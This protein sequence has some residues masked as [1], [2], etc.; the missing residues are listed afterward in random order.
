MAQF[1]RIYRL[2]W[3]TVPSVLREDLT[4]P[5]QVMVVN[6]YD[7]E[8]LIEDFQTPEVI[9]LQ[10]DADPLVI[11]IINNDE[12]KFS[13]IRA[14]Q[15]E[16]SFK[17]KTNLNQYSSTFAD[18]S[19]HRWK[20][21]ITADGEFVFIGFVVLADVEQPHLP[22]PNTVTLTASDHLGIL[23]DIPWTTDAGINPQGKYRI[24]DIIALCLK[25]TGLR[26]GITAVNNLRHGTGSI[27]QGATFLTSENSFI[28][29]IVTTFFYTGQQVQ[30]TGSGAN[31][32][33]FIVSS[34]ETTALTTKVF[35][36]TFTDDSVS[37]VTF[38]DLSSDQHFYDEIFLDA[39]TFETEI[40]ESDDCYTVLEKILGEDCFL[41]QWKGVWYILRI[42]EYD[43]NPIYPASFDAD[44]GFVSFDSP[45]SFSKSV[46]AAE[47]RRLANAD[48]L[49]RYDRQHGL[50]KETANLEYPKETICNI[51]YERG[52]ESSDPDLQ[53]DGYTAYEL[54]GWEAKRLWGA[55]EEPANFKSS[56]QRSFNLF[57]DEETRFIMLTKPAS[58][59][60]S[61]EYIR[62]CEVPMS[63]LDRFTFS[64][65]AAAL[66]DTSGD[67]SMLVCIILLYGID[68]N[69]YILRAA[70]LS[71]VWDN[72][73]GEVETQWRETDEE[74]SLFRDGMQWSIFDDG[75]HPP[76]TDWVS[77]IMNAAPLPVDG[78]V[79]FHLFSANQFA[80]TL[81]DF[82]IKYQNLTLDYRPYIGG[83]YQKYNKF[84]N[85]IT[86]DPVGY[87]FTKRER[88]VYI[89]DSPKPLFKGAMFF[90]N[91]ERYV[92]TSRWWSSAP[93]AL[94]PPPTQDHIHHYG[95]IQA[96]SVWNQYRNANRILPTSVLGMGS[97]WPDI[98]DKYSLTDSH[99]DK[100]NRYFLLI[101]FE[102]N[103]KT[104]LW[105]GVFIEVYSTV[106]PKN[107]TDDHELKYLT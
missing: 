3:N 20:V 96:Y 94:G 82:D 25:R 24:A 74:V 90:F 81:D 42:D 19:D 93:F 51:D 63:Y 55:D 4:I 89:F 11:K 91:G 32:Q 22:D 26:L 97:F 43:G 92:L 98:A 2:S 106:I 69:V 85:K 13:P 99:P 8:N 75:D 78:D 33:T 100:N 50:L 70:D 18:A 40:G 83:S 71:I 1:G 66:Q 5:A 14:K 105:S 60:G 41:T 102:Q 54:D 59:T 12:D 72:T 38:S 58:E 61:F 36:G 31:D 47:T 68:G 10:A 52:D 86:R 9:Q 57:G 64:F 15:A 17:S 6:I 95:F 29:S 107:Y 39:K 79:V 104:C 56:I 80:G 62:S 77:F 53:R 49:M 76:K 84:H 87:F 30:I 48:A 7:T 37:G 45:T 103:W 23:K 16:I 44:G 27:T 28:I 34:V 35:G 46:G 73:E 88:Q 67:G 101:S 21:E 65:E